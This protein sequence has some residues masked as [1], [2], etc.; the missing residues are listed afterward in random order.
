MLL[1]G[2]RN[3]Q[4]KEN[5]AFSLELKKKQTLSVGKQIVNTPY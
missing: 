4:N 1:G 3:Y 5:E 2:H